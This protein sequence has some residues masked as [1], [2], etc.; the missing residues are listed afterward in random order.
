MILFEYLRIN[1]PNKSKNNIKSLLKDECILVNDK[2]VTKY[3]YMVKDSDIVKIMNTKIGD[4]P[5]K[6]EDKYIIILVKPHN[7]LTIGNDKNE[8]NLYHLVSSYVKQKNKKN[9]IFIVHRLDYETSGLIMFAK[10]E[11]V[12]HL[13]QNNWNNV[14]RNYIALVKGKVKKEDIIKLKL[15][16]KGL[17]VY[18]DNKGKESILKYTLLKQNDY[19]SLV[20]INLIT[21]RKNQIRVSFKSIGSYVIGDSKYGKKEKIMYLFANELSFIHPITKKLVNIKCD[22]PSYFERRFKHE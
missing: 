3:D 17:N 5:I 20:K 21:G 7:L 22:I 9:K 19:N 13:L 14:T 8:K 15:I 18:V 2:V 12:K 11:K 6:Y 16:E 10:D 1:Y 4:I